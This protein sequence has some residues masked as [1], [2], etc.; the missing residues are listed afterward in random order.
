MGFEEVADWYW[1]LGIR[2]AIRADTTHP[3]DYFQMAGLLEVVR[4]FLRPPLG[5]RPEKKFKM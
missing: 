3:L 5:S 2:E 1:E 4:S